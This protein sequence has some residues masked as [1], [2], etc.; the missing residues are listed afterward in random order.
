MVNIG[1]NVL[2][3][4]VKSAAEWEWSRRFISSE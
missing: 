1:V 2:V 3:D 4:S